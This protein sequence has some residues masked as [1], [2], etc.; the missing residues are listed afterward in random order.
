M[1]LVGLNRLPN[2]ALVGGIEACRSGVLWHAQI[3]TS[4]AAYVWLGAH[5]A[6]ANPHDAFGEFC[7][8][9]YTK[10]IK[11]VVSYTQKQR[12]SPKLILLLLIHQ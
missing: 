8:L 7:I 2:P 10:F 12:D 5:P 4:D 3:M 11:S 1:Y 6:V 9:S